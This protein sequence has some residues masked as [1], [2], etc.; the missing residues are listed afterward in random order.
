MLRKRRR[1][2]HSDTEAMGHD[3]PDAIPVCDTAPNVQDHE[4]QVESDSYFEDTSV[5]MV[6]S[7]TDVEVIDDSDD[8]GDQ[9]SDDD[10]SS[11]STSSS[12]RSSVRDNDRVI[13][14]NTDI[15]DN[16]AQDGLQVE[17][18]AEVE[19]S[20]LQNSN[21]AGLGM[22]MCG[23]SVELPRPRKQWQLLRRRRRVVESEADA[24]DSDAAGTYQSEPVDLP[25]A[26]ILPQTKRWHCLR[27]RRRVVQSDSDVEAGEAAT[28][29]HLPGADLL[30]LP[31]AK[32][33][34]LQRQRK[35]WHFLRKRLR[36]VESDTE[37]GGSAG[38]PLR[39]RRL[40]HRRWGRHRVIDDL[41]DREATADD[42][43]ASK[44]DHRWL[45]DL[46]WQVVQAFLPV[47]ACD[48]VACALVSASRSFPQPLRAGSSALLRLA[49]AQHRLELA[50]DALESLHIAR[51]APPLT[52]H[53]VIS[54]SLISCALLGKSTETECRAF[55]ATGE[56]PTDF[57]PADEVAAVEVLQF[58]SHPFPETRYAMI[59]ALGYLGKA[60]ALAALPQV[61]RMLADGSRMV[62]EAAAWSLDFLC[63]VEPALAAVE[64]AK[65][66]AHGRS[67]PREAALEAL[68]HLG[69]DLEA[70]VPQ[71]RSLLTHRKAAVRAAAARALGLMAPLLPELSVTRELMALLHDPD[72]DVRFRARSA[73]ISLGSAAT[74]AI[75]EL[76]LLLA[77][78]GSSARALA[79]QVLHGL[80]ARI[81]PA[82]PQLLKL[83]SDRRYQVRAAAISLLGLS[84]GGAA[85]AEVS[86]Q[87]LELVAKAEPLLVQLL[88]DNKTAVRFAAQEALHMLDPELYSFPAVRLR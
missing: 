35:A 13:E 69:A 31:T 71:V 51:H 23:P 50:I 4:S 53:L 1:V 68:S 8:E 79:L 27:K 81:V 87:V 2:V 44:P 29:R 33:P 26:E 60:A 41:S 66:L 61:V 84:L 56:L 49:V 30:R 45:P 55:L 42:A 12:S 6:E 36:V 32:P 15:E 67:Y 39:L 43:S 48:H 57:A 17:C 63:P 65:L 82:V 75:P 16:D 88:T 19:D 18:D 28:G 46:A 78:S 10:S 52:H 9:S 3:A 59:V 34:L 72:W 54:Q 86:S 47:P 22:S 85:A 37:S 64:L 80:G 20:D 76:V 40:S 83:L 58:A 21:Q 11:S 62:R 24:S 70:A 14:S 7:G 25:S 38:F 5:Q 73:L 77:G 74:E